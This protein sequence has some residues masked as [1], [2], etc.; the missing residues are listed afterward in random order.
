MPVRAPR[1]VLLTPFYPSDTATNRVH[2]AQPSSLAAPEPGGD[3]TAAHA[4]R[5]AGQGEARA[6]HLQPQGGRC[7]SRMRPLA[8]ESRG[9]RREDCG[10][11][12][13]GAAP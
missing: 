6:T 12:A 7:A 1:R 3:S 11:R 8:T 13:A 9:E 4:E 10:A 5:Q 2:K